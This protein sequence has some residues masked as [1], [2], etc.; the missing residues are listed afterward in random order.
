ML[1]PDRV[2]LA[3][4][5]I[6]NPARSKRY[7]IPAWPASDV[8]LPM[9]SFVVLLATLVAVAA[10]PFLRFRH[11]RPQQRQQLKWLAFATGVSAFGIFTG[12][13]LP[14]GQPLQLLLF[15]I[16]A[17]GIALGLPAAVGIAILRYRLYDIDRLINRT[18]VYGLLTAILGLS[19]AGIVLLLG[20]Y[21]AGLEGIPRAGQSPAPPS[22]LLPCSSRPAAA[23]GG[24]GIAR[25]PS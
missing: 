12:N 13:L 24:R 6:P 15:G 1:R 11:A 9:V 17:T 2:S 16:G 8:R 14:P 21:L 19:Y 22:P 20:R 25:L 18:L 4:H 5:L 10:A 23:S 3:G 7:R